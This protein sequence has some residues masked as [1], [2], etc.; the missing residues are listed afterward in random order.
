MPRSF[1][2]PVGEVAQSAFLHHTSWQ[3]DDVDEVGRGAMLMLEKDPDRHVCGLGRH[4]VGSNF[5]WYL[6]GPGRELLRVL[7]PPRLHRRRRAV[8]HGRGPRACSTGVRRLSPSF[9]MPE[10]LAARMTGHTVPDDP[11]PGDGPLWVPSPGS[12][13]T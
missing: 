12:F 10:D 7:L 2:T 13:A 3:V 5:F 1:S 4:H 9:V 8:G 6:K 11:D